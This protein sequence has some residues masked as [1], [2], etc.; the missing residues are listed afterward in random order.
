[1][2]DTFH[3][4]LTSPVGRFIFWFTNDDLSGPYDDNRKDEY[5]RRCKDVDEIIQ[6]T[7][8]E[9]HLICKG[10][11]YSRDP[12]NITLSSLGE[13]E[14]LGEDGGYL[15]APDMSK[16]VKVMLEL[17]KNQGWSSSPYINLQTYRP[18]DE[19]GG[20]LYNTFLLEK[21]MAEV[22]DKAPES[23]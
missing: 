14:V 9:R 8:S 4:H 5:I 15:Y 19:G 16:L 22:G 2:S 17:C 3:E 13:Y 12:K 10:V 11:G 23:S 1:M 18:N 21:F 20:Y 6:S 7:F